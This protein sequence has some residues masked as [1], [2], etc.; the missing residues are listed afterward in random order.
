[1]NQTVHDELVEI[2]DLR[3]SIHSEGSFF[4]VVKG[5]SLSIRANEIVC[6]VGESGCGKSITALSVMGLLPADVAGVTGGEIFY[7]GQSLLGLSPREM[8]RVRSEEISM[9]FQDPTTSLDPVFTIG[10][11]LKEVIRAHRDVSRSEAE[12]LAVRALEEAQLPDARKRLRSYPHELSGGM[13]QRVMIALATALNP[14][15]LIADEPTTALD[16][17]V[18]AEVLDLILSL[19]K[20][21]SMSCLFITH[22][23]GVIAQICD[24]VAVMYAGQII[25]T[26]KVDDIFSNPSH[27]YT[28]GLLNSTLRA[29]KISPI[30]VIPGEVAD[31]TNIP[32]GCS[33]NPRCNKVHDT[34]YKNIPKNVELNSNH[35]VKCHLF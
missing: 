7:R 23:L 20:S 4:E 12:E 21:K 29:D 25:E 22:D 2:R 9:I 24:R 13:R 16:V 1:M 19:V 35:L 18:Q 31:P 11:L 3:I 8:R 14:A 5:V 27:P 26:G 10:S 15:V 32:Q 28:I 33:F 17:T 34:C 30:H 6:L